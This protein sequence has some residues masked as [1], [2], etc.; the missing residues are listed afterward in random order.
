MKEKT[1]RF[2]F[3]YMGLSSTRQKCFF[4][5][6]TCYF[7]SLLLTFIDYEFSTIFF[8]LTAIM[9]V[10]KLL[11]LHFDVYHVER[12]FKKSSDKVVIDIE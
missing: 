7:I 12:I 4:I 11:L 10:Y 1:Y 5:I 3:P 8:L 2:L 6:I 9:V